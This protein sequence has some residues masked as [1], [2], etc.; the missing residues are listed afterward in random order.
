MRTFTRAHTGLNTRNRGELPHQ[1]S[2]HAALRMAGPPRTRRHLRRREGA[3]DGLPCRNGRRRYGITHIKEECVF[4]GLPLY[5][6][7]SI[8]GLEIIHRI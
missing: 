4:F 2:A 5:A 1:C 8:S 6:V 7:I 3:V